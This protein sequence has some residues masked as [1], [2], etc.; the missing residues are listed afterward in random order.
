MILLKEGVHMAE[1]I[2]VNPRFSYEKV[3]Q[4]RKIY[5]IH[6]HDEYELYHLVDGDTKYFVD[7]EVF[8]L[9]KGSFIFV[10]KGAIH[11]TDS[12]SCL[13]N[14]RI[15]LSFSD[16][17]FDG[18]MQD[19]LNELKSQK[20]IL[21]PEKHLPPIKGIIAALESEFKDEKHF[22]EPLIKSYLKSLLILLCRYKT[23]PKTQSDGPD[24][25]ILGI[26]E[27]ISENLSGEISLSALSRDFSISEGHLSR[28]FKEV[29]GVG[30]N[31]YIRFVRMQRAANLLTFTDDSITKI[32]T[33]CGFNDSN[34]FSTVFKHIFG[35]TPRKYRQ[36]HL[37]L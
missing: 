15:L 36:K 20:L 33:S 1:K 5:P 21:I 12:E 2:T 30:L 16:D 29:M 4:K 14:E 11:K 13:H 6:R 17:I 10:P 26:A 34:Y 3:M 22:K 23:E 27:Y 18:D 31:E 37:S 7:N 9:P 19:V 32:A 25:F 28:R 24:G 8:H 35:A